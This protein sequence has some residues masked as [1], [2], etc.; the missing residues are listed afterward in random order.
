VPQRGE[1]VV[2]RCVKREKTHRRWGRLPRRLSGV[3]TA[4]SA[5]EIAGAP[6][7]EPAASQQADVLVLATNSRARLGG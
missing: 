5:G 3:T 2:E 6:I 1:D 4:G 7:A